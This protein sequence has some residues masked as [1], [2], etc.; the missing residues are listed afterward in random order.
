MQEWQKR[1]LEAIDTKINNTTSNLNFDKTYKGI[2]ETVADN[3]VEVY[4]N[5][6]LYAVNI[7]KGF[8]LN[9]GDVVAITAIGNNFNDLWIDGVLSGQGGYVPADTVRFSDKS[10][11]HNQIS[12][13]TIWDINHDLNKF[14]NITIVDSA[15]NVVVGDIQYISENEIAVV[16][17]APFSGKAYLN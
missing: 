3:L 7:Q 16:F 4:I 1:V 11:V 8:E 13:S 10:Y 5:G 12:A 15:G 17:S 6:E 2:V 9:K 14:P